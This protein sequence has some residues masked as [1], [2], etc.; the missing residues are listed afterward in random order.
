MKTI[1]FIFNILFLLIG[2][3]Y[4]VQ[5]QNNNIDKVILPHINPESEIKTIKDV[6]FYY[7][8][9]TDKEGKLIFFKK[10][11]KNISDN[12]IDTFVLYKNTNYSTHC[13][14]LKE[15]NKHFILFVELVP[16]GLRGETRMLIIS[17]DKFG[18]LIWEKNL[19][20]IPFSIEADE[21]IEN[22]YVLCNRPAFR[23]DGKGRILY[24][25]E[26]LYLNSNG[27]I[28]DSFRVSNQFQENSHQDK[29]LVKQKEELLIVK[30]SGYV[31]KYS[32]EHINKLFPTRKYDFLIWNIQNQE[33]KDTFS[34][35]T[36]GILFSVGFIENS[37]Y[38]W[39]KT[40]NLNL[41]SLARIS[42]YDFFLNRNNILLKDFSLSFNRIDLK[43]KKN[44]SVKIISN[45]PHSSQIF[46]NY[47][48]SCYA[49]FYDNINSL[50][51][52]G[53]NIKENSSNKFLIEYEYESGDSMRINDIII[54][55]N[56]FYII[57]GGFSKNLRIYN[58]YIKTI[59]IPKNI[60]LTNCKKSSN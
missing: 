54:D 35:L 1:I 52:T 33:I 3:T 9:Y 40:K 29:Y 15:V 53:L 23:Y 56:F 46:F 27:D 26:L 38:Y 6:F 34:V 48:D 57:L 19:N 13:L 50:N 51:L 12:L 55:N 22:Y 32:T 31:K 30:Q 11:L 4:K 49:C 41:D 17:L 14:D 21:S 7:G 37:V 28:K 42:K 45:Y 20:A 36:A 44:T 43:T 39:E 59:E 18:N 8:I 47:Q 16:L 60:M 25:L 10:R 24:F 2:S 58:M 5:S